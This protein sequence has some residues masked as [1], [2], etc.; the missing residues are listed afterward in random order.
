MFCA[1]VLLSALDTFPI[2]ALFF[3][4]AEQHPLF[5]LGGY[6]AAVGNALN[7]ESCI[8]MFVCS[9]IFHC[10]FCFL[11]VTR[12]RFQVGVSLARNSIDC[13]RRVDSGLQSE[14]R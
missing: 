11:H 14:T 7:A 13:L 5:G 6:R 2:L 4:G 8:R 10:E 12:F 1:R 3:P 9:V